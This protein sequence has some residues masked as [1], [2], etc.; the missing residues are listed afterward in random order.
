[1]D[2][3]LGSG[4]VIDERNNSTQLIYSTKQTKYTF[5]LAPFGAS[6]FFQ[7]SMFWRR[8]RYRYI[9]FNIHNHSCWDAELVRDLL[10]SGAIFANSSQFLSVFR[11][12]TNSISGSG[13]LAKQHLDWR[14]EQSKVL[15]GRDINIFDKFIGYLIRIFNLSNALVKSLRTELT[16][17]R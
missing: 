14:R 13:R 4:I 10:M 11:K 3:L 2:V 5:A 6:V 16:R 12:H 15:L 1:V 17:S 9:D 8:D 7:P